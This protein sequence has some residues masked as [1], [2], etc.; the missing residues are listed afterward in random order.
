MYIE[1]SGGIAGN[2]IPQSTGIATSGYLQA[3]PKHDGLCPHC[4]RCPHCGQPKPFQFQTQIYPN[5]IINYPSLSS[6]TN[7][8]AN[9]SLPYTAHGWNEQRASAQ[10]G[11]NVGHGG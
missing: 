4:G 5:S 11:A 6:Q 9:S 3:V 8:T 1:N 7:G 10:S 2:A